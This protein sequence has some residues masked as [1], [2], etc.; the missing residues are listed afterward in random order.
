MVPE[1]IGSVLH[2]W[3]PWVTFRTLTLEEIKNSIERAD[4]TTFIANCDALEEFTNE[5]TEP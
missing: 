3:D 1:L 5:P 4:A 2:E